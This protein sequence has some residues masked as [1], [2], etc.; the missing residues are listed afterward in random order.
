MSE[1]FFT[2]QIGLEEYIT[3]NRFIDI[4]DT[5]HAVFCKTD[6]VLEHRDQAVSVFMTHN[7][8]YHITSKV[9]EVRPKG[10]KTWYAQNKDYES[11]QLVCI[12]IGLENMTLRVTPASQL[13]R[14]SSRP[15]QGLEKALHI[16]ALAKQSLKHDGF[17]YLNHN[18]NTFPSERNHVLE[19]F[20]GQDWVTRKSS[21]PWQ[22]YY[23][24]IGTHKFVFSPRG[25]GVDCHRTWEA[26]YLRTIPIVRASVAMQDFKELPILFVNKWEEITYD[27][28]IQ[29]YEEM[30]GQLYDLSKMKISY[31]KEKIG[32]IGK[33]N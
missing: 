21:V 7:S 17:V 10:L 19:L 16:S 3:G 6:F 2:H 5:S 33:S 26:L 28:L 11:E 31:W 23:Q 1:D 20:G 15:A 25:N 32:G 8:D 22:E 4:A 27:F 30:K 13:G 12:P 29:K 9:F 14:Y 18:A 24:D